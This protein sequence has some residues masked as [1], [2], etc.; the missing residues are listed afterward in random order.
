M[1]PRL[2]VVTVRKES[3]VVRHKLLSAVGLEVTKGTFRL[4]ESLDDLRDRAGTD[5]QK[6]GDSADR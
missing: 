5:F 6:L 2:Q 1:S 4:L 3:N